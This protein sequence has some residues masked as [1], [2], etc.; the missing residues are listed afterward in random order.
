MMGDTL[1]TNDTQIEFTI[2]SE[3]ASGK[4]VQLCGVDGVLQQWEV[5]DAQWHTSTWLLSPVRT[6][7]TNSVLNSALNVRRFLLLI[8]HSLVNTVYFI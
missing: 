7:R 8:L 2:Q 1:H 6:H 3:G 4:R 5:V